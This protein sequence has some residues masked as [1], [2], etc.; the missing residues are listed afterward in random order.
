MQQS[1]EVVSDWS[2]LDATGRKNVTDCKSWGIQ[3]QLV[4]SINVS[5]RDKLTASL[6]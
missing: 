1:M 3:S 6:S 2:D 5:L 4:I